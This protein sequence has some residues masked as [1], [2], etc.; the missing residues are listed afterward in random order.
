MLK[1]HTMYLSRRI[2]PF[3]EQYLASFPIVGIT[4]P[5]QSGKSTLLKSFLKNDYKYITFD[6]LEIRSIFNEDPVRFME[7]HNNRVIFDEVQYVPDLFNRIK[8]LVDNDRMNYGKFILTGSSQFIM[9]KHISESLAGRIGLL[10]LLPFQFSEIPENIQSESILKG[11]YP[12]L[13]VRGFANSEIWY[14]SYI[15]TYL[16]KD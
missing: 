3:L 1:L 13:V 12:E 11:S 15:N 16:Q 5:R 6:D 8:V 4:G 7:K 14:N 9:N 10:N 2:E